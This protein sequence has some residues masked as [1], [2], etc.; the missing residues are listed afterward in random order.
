MGLALAPDVF[1]AGVALSG[2]CNL[3]TRLRATAIDP[4]V[5]AFWAHWLGDPD[6]DE[7]FLQSRSPLSLVDR[8][9]GPVLIA[10]AGRDARG[11]VAGSDQLVAALRRAGQTVEY[12]V[13]PDE[14]H[15]LTRA[16]NRLHFYARAEA[17]LARHVGGRCE[18]L[19]EIAGHAGADM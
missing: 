8:I 18:P 9:K 1:A 3:V 2:T 5:R 4:A 10:M 11:Q 12:L 13:Y 15:A 6:R 14:G 17:F 16:A 19:H 7:A